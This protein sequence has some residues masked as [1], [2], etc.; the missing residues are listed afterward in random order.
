VPENLGRFD[1][2]VFERCLGA[3]PAFPAQDIAP[4]A[5]ESSS[6]ERNSFRQPDSPSLLPGGIPHIG[7]T[8]DTLFAGQGSPSVCAILLQA[9]TERQDVGGLVERRH[10]RQ[11]D[12]RNLPTSQ[13][14][15]DELVL[16]EPSKLGTRCRIDLW[17]NSM[18]KARLQKTRRG[19]YYSFESA[20]ISYRR[21]FVPTLSVAIRKQP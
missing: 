12:S 17:Y 20:E 11:Y 21:E 18:R 15:P 2:I 16:L 14:I 5:V 19:I 3:Y 9:K 6:A 1:Y 4:D 7:L 10:K 13:E 8:V